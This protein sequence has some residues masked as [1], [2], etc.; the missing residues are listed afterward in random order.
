MCIRDRDK[1]IEVSKSK[2]F[3]GLKST[4]SVKPI[5]IAI[6]VVVKYKTRVLPAI[7]PKLKFLSKDETPL[8]SE[9]NTNGTTINFNKE[10]NI[11]PPIFKKPSIKYTF[12]NGLASNP[13]KLM[14]EPNIRPESIPIKI[15][16]V[17]LI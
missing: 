4:A 11:C 16:E 2:L 5:D 15:F 8:V 1:D 12:M 3:P 13:N 7:L 17:R 9:K 10:I 6:A 14:I